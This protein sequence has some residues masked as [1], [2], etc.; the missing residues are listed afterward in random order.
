MADNL[1]EIH[2]NDLKSCNPDDVTDRT[3]C[4]FN[5]RSGEY[6]VNVWGKDY[7]VAPERYQIAPKKDGGSTYQDFLYLFILH[8]LT[9]GKKIPPSGNWVSEKDI[10]G[11]EGFFRGPHLLPVRLIVE[12]VNDNLS[13]FEKKCE[14]LN[15]SR[16]DFADAAY[17]FNITPVI[18]VAVLYWQGDDD[19]P[20]EAKLLF[21]KTIDQH[22]ALDII[23]ALGVEICH[24][25]S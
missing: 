5:V 15:G 2:F 21:D 8:Y 24:A 10:P 7:I 20:G 25:L 23:Y 17:C 14:L 18:P 11:G 13:V 19:F 1:N 16:I 9:N 12:S 3:G 6:T 4:L 22:L